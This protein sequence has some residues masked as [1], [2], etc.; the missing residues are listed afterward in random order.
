MFQIK[1]PSSLSRALLLAAG[2]AVAAP[3]LALGLAPGQ[4]QAR[5]LAENA[6]NGSST[7]NPFAYSMAVTQPREAAGIPEAVGNNAQ[8]TGNPQAAGVATTRA[9]GG[10]ALQ[11]VGNSANAFGGFGTG[12]ARG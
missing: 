8:A 10:P 9:Q 7:G 2:V 11:A 6:N 4:A 5:D 12:P 3:M 1:S